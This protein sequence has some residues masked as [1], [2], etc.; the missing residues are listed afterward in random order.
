MDSNLLHDFVEE[1]RTA[2]A[3]GCQVVPRPDGTEERIRYEAMDEPSKILF[4][5]ACIDF[6]DYVNRGMEPALGDQILEN[7]LAGKPSDRWLE[8]AL[9]AEGEELVRKYYAEATKAPQ[10]SE[11]DQEPSR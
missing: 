6:T 8:G 5:H 4:L 9:G 10:L 7:V 11:R 2:I 1:V 3:E